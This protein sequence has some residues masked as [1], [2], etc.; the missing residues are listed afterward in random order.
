MDLVLV[1][2]KGDPLGG[3]FAKAY[4][5]AGG[6][7]ISAIIMLPERKERSF[8]LREKVAASCKLLSFTGMIRLLRARAHIPTRVDAR[9]GLHLPWPEFMGGTAT[10][11]LTWPRINDAAAISCLQEIQPDIL[12]SIGSP[13]ILRPEI[14]EIPLLGTINVHNGLLPKYRGHFGTFWEVYNHEPW[15]YISIHE[16]VAKVDSGKILARDRVAISDF[17]TF[18]DLLLEKKQKGGA[19]LA[20]LLQKIES[21]GGFPPGLEVGGEAPVTSGYYGWPALQDLRRLSWRQ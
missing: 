18:F 3:V 8:N 15:G 2:T 16:M 11:I 17:P 7:P 4:Q 12:L 10:R 5:D 1:T 19:L 21:R 6:P 13:V 9:R 14:L 20:D